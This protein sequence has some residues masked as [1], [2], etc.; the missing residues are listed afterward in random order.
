[1]H[2]AVGPSKGCHR[3]VKLM[4]VY[5]SALRLCHSN[6]CLTHGDCA[7]RGHGEGAAPVFGALLRAAH[8][9]FRL[10]DCRALCRTAHD[11]SCHNLCVMPLPNAWPASAPSSSAYGVEGNPILRRLKAPLPQRMQR[12]TV[13]AP[14][15]LM[16]IQTAPLRDQHT[17]AGQARSASFTGELVQM[18]PSSILSAMLPSLSHKADGVSSLSPTP[19]HWVF[20]PAHMCTVTHTEPTSEWET[21]LPGVVGSCPVKPSLSIFPGCTL[22][23][24]QLRPAP[25][26]VRVLPPAAG[27]VPASR[28]RAAE[29]GGAGGAPPVGGAGAAGGGGRTAVLLGVGAGEG[30]GAG[31]AA[32]G[33]WL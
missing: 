25:M 8:L 27:R 12:R 32:A 1:M 7:A 24:R 33:G 17:V 5:D 20:A 3:G 6:P 26:Q 16:G 19:M 18:C 31:G 2:L 28:R 22:R 14:R 29:R 13:A 21:Q 11:A 23:Q 9:A 30:A 10:Q 15:E 4:A